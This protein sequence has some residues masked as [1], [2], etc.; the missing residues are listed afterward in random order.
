VKRVLTRS[1][2]SITPNG[3]WIPFGVRNVVAK[4]VTIVTETDESLSAD[5]L[6]PVKGDAEDTEKCVFAA[7]RRCQLR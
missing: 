3:M 7:M 6:S 4:W 5:A 2:D 1:D